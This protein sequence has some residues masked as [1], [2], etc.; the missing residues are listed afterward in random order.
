MRKKI[1]V[2]IGIMTMLTS[3]FLIPGCGSGDKGGVDRIST[4]EMVTHSGDTGNTN[5]DGGGNPGGGAGDGAC[6][7]SAFGMTVCVDTS[8]SP[9][10][11][12]SYC[13]LANGTW[14]AGQ[15][16]SGLGY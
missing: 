15:T 14:N 4:T 3:L 9:I 1:I 10:F 12:E 5:P 7:I 11:D 8:Q 16:C 13:N 6:E 2:V